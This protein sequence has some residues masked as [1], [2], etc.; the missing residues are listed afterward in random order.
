MNKLNIPDD[1][2][3]IIGDFANV[4]LE[5]Y[6]YKTKK[7]NNKMKITKIKYKC[8][9]CNKKCEYD[10]YSHLTLLCD[11]CR[12]ENYI[13]VQDETNKKWLDLMDEIQY[14]HLYDSHYMKYLKFDKLNN[15]IKEK[16]NIYSYKSPRLIAFVV[17][18]H[19]I[20]PSKRQIR[21]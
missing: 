6:K 11:Q 19:K 10:E 4:S 1:V 18:N 3:N 14:A 20:P 7:L 21:I 9:I 5:T 16:Y 17:N 15:Q 12:Y 13:V 8:Y 2:L